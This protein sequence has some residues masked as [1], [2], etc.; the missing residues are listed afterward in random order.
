MGTGFADDC[1]LLLHRKD[2]QQA[3]DL[4]QRA[5]KELTEWG[6]NAGL[7]FNPLKTIV[8]MFT[9][10]TKPSFPKEVVMDGKNICLLYTSDAADE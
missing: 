1:S 7:K 2:P 9:R 6:Q 5:L 10:T 4:I 8:I 3:V